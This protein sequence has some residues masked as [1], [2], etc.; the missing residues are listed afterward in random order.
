VALLE[1]PPTEEIARSISWGLLQLMGQVAREHGFQRPFLSALCDPSA[2]LTMGCIVLAAKLAA[3]GGN[4]PR[5][6]ALWD[7]GGNPEY[8][9]QVLAR[10]ARYRVCVATRESL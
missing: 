4:V 3:A 5:A 10:V 1:L 8:A 9:G 7:G 6:L 2:G